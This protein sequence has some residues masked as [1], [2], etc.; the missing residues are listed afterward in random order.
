MIESAHDSSSGIASD[1]HNSYPNGHNV[2]YTSDPSYGLPPMPQPPPHGYAGENRYGTKAFHGLSNPA[3]RDGPAHQDHQRFCSMEYD[4]KEKALS[5]RAMLPDPRKHR[6]QKLKQ[7]D[8]QIYDRSTVPNDDYYRT[9]SPPENIF[10]RN[11]RFMFT[12]SPQTFDI[13][14]HHHLH[15]THIQDVNNL[16][17]FAAGGNGD[18]EDSKQCWFDLLPDD[19]I[20]RILSNLTSTEL[21]RNTMVCRRWY[22]LAWE[23]CLWTSI[24]IIRSTIDVDRSLK[25]LTRRLSLDTPSVCVMVEKIFLNGCE[26]LTDKGLHTIAKRCPELRHL[27]LHGCQ[28][29]SNIALFEVVSKCVNMEHLNVAGKLRLMHYMFTL[30]GLTIFIYTCT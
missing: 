17:T 9:F 30:K 2:T 3:F 6:P 26:K 27:E 10:N 14:H 1:E 5:P 13:Q 15:Q 7:T 11:Y 21:C 16:I 12:Q 24:R 19:V 23:P 22:H 20:I 25:V 28:G 29:I 18:M 8:V 4:E